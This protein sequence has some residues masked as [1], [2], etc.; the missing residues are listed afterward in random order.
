VLTNLG[1]VSRSAGENEQARAYQEEA[2]ALW[3]ALNNKFIL[4][5][6]LN[7]LGNLVLDQGQKAEA[8]RYLEEAVAVQREVGHKWYLA[9]ALNNLG[10]VAREQGD[11]VA[12]SNLY[13]E[14]IQL[15]QELGDQWALA[16]LLEDSG[17]LAA[18]QGQAERA[19]KL[20]GSAH[21]VRSVIKASLSSNEQARLDSKLTSA[22]QAMGDEGQAVWDAGRGLTLGEAIEYAMN[23]HE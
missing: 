11:Y 5:I 23:G 16:Y 9:N 21:A 20:V 2:I 4:A 19:L 7:N 10:N 6:S 13:K 1:A 15:Y 12:A 14:G 22:R 8:R 18:A 17:L 3:R